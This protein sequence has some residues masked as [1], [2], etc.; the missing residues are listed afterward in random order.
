MHNTAAAAE[1]QGKRRRQRPGGRSL[2]VFW[3]LHNL[4]AGVAPQATEKQKI[5]SNKPNRRIIDT[6]PTTINK[7]RIIEMILIIIILMAILILLLGDED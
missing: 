4:G 7:K 1:R 3:G 6:N 5:P 2:G